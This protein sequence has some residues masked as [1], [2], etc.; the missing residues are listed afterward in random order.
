MDSV[1]GKTVLVVENDLFFSSRIAGALKSMGLIPIVTS[2]ES[3]IDETLAAG[4]PA[5]AIVDMAAGP[6]DPLAVIAKL[7]SPGVPVPVIAFGEHTNGV[8]L[9]EARRAGCEQVVTN[10][11]LTASLK[12]LVFSCLG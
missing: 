2:S 10:G 4:A 7:K 12:E 3:R 1:P 6:L 9:E 8:A 11:K 5:L